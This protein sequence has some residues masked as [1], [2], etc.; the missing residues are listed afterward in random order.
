MRVALEGW[1][2][3]RYPSARVMHEL[4]VGGCRIDLAFVTTTHLFGV[5]IK[6]SK[7]TLDRLD[8]QIEHFTRCLPEVWVAIA[9]K[10]IPAFSPGSDTGL[11]WK[12][13]RL[14]VEGGAVREKIPFGQ[15]YASPHPAI[16]D[17]MLTTSM[18]HLLHVPELV[19][20]ATAHRLPHRKRA[21]SRD[22][23]TLLARS[24]TGDDVVAGVCGQLRAR[25]TGWQADAPHTLPACAPPAETIALP[26]LS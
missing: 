4:P 23:M 25:P 2:R 9:E 19:A 5:E 13:G 11:P 8:K 20:L 1:G 14:I 26:G 15:G 3:A 6:S 17:K 7:D 24:L 12:V 21:P 10:W 16:I 18:L 22:L